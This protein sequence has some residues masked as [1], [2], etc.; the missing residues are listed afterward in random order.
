MGRL[1]GILM[2]YEDVLTEMTFQ[3]AE[4]AEEGG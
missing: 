2:N 3:G 1:G 4:G